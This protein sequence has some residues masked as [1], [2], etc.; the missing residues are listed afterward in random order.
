MLLGVA[1]MRQLKS[2]IICVI[3]RIMKEM[4]TISVI[5]CPCPCYLVNKSSYITA[6][7]WWR[8]QMETFSV[9]LAMCARNSP[10]TYKFH[11]QRQSDADHW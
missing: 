9:I 5:T 6:V 1:M 2:V 11:T 7:A 8:H 4:Q 10:A 3:E